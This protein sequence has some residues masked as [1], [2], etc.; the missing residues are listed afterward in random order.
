MMGPREEMRDRAGAPAVSVPPPLRRG[1][2]LAPPGRWWDDRHAIKHLGIR[3]DQQKRMDD[4]FEANKAQLET[5]L[6]NLQRE[7]THLANL[8]PDEMRDEGKVFAAI[9][10]VTQARAELEKADAHIELQLRQQLD[11]AQLAVLDK[12]LAEGR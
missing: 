4:L 9:D 2:Q 10:R 5:L 6:G 11:P 1:L 8:T 3:Q 7:E 12:D